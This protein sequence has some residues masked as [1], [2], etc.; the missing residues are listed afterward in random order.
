MY[1]IQSVLDRWNFAITKCVKKSKYLPRRPGNDLI[2]TAEMCEIL[3]SLSSRTVTGT[4][5]RNEVVE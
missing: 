3:N 2:Y 5:G 4:N 1:L